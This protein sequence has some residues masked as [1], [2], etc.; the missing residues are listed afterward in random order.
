MDNAIEPGSVRLMEAAALEALFTS[1]DEAGYRV[2][3]PTVRDG[4]IVLDELAVVGD[5]PFGW[6]ASSRSSRSWT[7]RSRSSSMARW[8]CE[9]G[10]TMR[11]LRMVPSASISY[12]W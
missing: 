4:A 2:I 12:R 10:G 6:V 1:L 9:V 8:F 7:K 3:G 5:L 11:A